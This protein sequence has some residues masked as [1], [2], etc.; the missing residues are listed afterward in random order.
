VPG[1]NTPQQRQARAREDYHD[2]TAGVGGAPPALSALT[3]RLALAAFGLLACTAGAVV[4]LVVVS[5]PVS[6]GIFAFFAAVALVDLAVVTRRKLR[7][8]PG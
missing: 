3:P 1:N 2:P 5:Q 7:G 8:E 4:F 6:A